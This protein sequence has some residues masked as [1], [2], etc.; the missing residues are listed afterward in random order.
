MRGA[1]AWGLTVNRKVNGILRLVRER[2]IASCGTSFASEYPLFRL[3]SKNVMVIKKTV[4]PLPE[5][6]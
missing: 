5:E 6:F 3:L 1:I 4:P 2:R